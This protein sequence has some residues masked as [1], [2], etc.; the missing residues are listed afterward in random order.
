MVTIAT[1]QKE[2]DAHL[3][4]NR[5]REMGI[6]VQVINSAGS[7]WMPYLSSAVELQVN[8]ADL[9]KLAEQ[10]NTFLEERTFRCPECGSTRYTDKVSFRDHFWGLFVVLGC[11]YNKRQVP[12]LVD[13]SLA[14]RC[15]DCGNRFRVDTS[16]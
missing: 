15:S 9:E 5:L 12:D 16:D 7:G 8:T 1:Y 11:L 2:E 3:E 10:E 14:Y 4:A 13:E 6:E